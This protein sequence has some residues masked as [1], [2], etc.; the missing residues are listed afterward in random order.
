MKIKNAISLANVQPDLS[1]IKA[2][3]EKA[4]SSDG[5]SR[6]QVLAVK[7]TI[8]P[9][10]LPLPLHERGAAE[11]FSLLI[12]QVNPQLYEYLAIVNAIS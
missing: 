2:L 5:E 10:Q 7:E 11:M 1:A 4:H 8:H 9:K 6:K 12:A 3:I